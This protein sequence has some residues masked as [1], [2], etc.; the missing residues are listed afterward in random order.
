VRPPPT[1][2]TTTG[3]AS[4]SRSTTTPISPGTRLSQPFGTARRQGR[5]SPSSSA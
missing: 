2:S 5:R 4:S 3:R 1:R